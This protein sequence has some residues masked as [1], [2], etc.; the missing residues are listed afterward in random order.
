MIINFQERTCAMELVTLIVSFYTWPYPLKRA[1][2]NFNGAQQEPKLLEARY[3][4]TGAQSPENDSHC[5][6]TCS[7][8]EV[9]T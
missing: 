5:F 4:L 9:V 2:I 1:S 6:D 8:I 3:F 7:H